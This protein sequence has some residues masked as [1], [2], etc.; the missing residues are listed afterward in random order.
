MARPVRFQLQHAAPIHSER[1]ARCL[2]RK[3]ARAWRK[4]RIP[5]IVLNVSLA[6]HHPSMRVLRDISLRRLSA[7]DMSAPERPML[8]GITADFY[9][10]DQPSICQYT[11]IWMK[12]PCAGLN[13]CRPCGTV[14]VSG[15]SLS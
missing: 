6:F 13:V 15:I 10:E 11:P 5:A 8:S 12:I 3:R 7:L 14:R 4:R 1:P 2:G 9:P